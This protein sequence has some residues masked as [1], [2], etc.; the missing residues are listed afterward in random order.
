MKI[1]GGKAEVSSFWGILHTSVSEAFAC[2]Q[3]EQSS[4]LGHKL[5]LNTLLVLS[6]IF[7]NFLESFD[8]MGAALFLRVGLWSSPKIFIGRGFWCIVSSVDDLY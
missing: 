1:Q 8:S 5:L 3:M 7:A 4:N 6:F 2:L